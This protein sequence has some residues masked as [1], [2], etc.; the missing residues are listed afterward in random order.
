MELLSIY[1][2]FAIF[3][4]NMYSIRQVI[5][6][7]KIPVSLF[8][9]TVGAWFWLFPTLTLGVLGELKLIMLYPFFIILN[10]LSILFCSNY[11]RRKKHLP[12]IRNKVLA[13]TTDKVMVR[14][15]HILSVL[16][17]IVILPIAYVFIKHL[18]II[19]KAVTE[20]TS[21]ILPWDTLIYHYT[22]II[23]FAQE[24]TLWTF[25]N[26]F[27]SYF[28]G[29]E[30]IGLLTGLI[31]KK[32][33]P[34]IILNQYAI[35][36]LIISLVVVCNR[37]YIYS[38]E[39][40]LHFGKNI[41]TLFVIALFVICFQSKLNNIG[42][43]DIFQ[44]ATIL[45]CMAF[46]LEFFKNL[47][48][49]K[50]SSSKSI[51]LAASGASLALGLITKP[52][53]IA[54]YMYFNVLL[55]YGL[56]FTAKYNKLNIIKGLVIFNVIVL[57]LGSIFFIRNIVKYQGLS[58]SYWQASFKK[59]ILYNLN[60][61]HLFQLKPEI[62][63][64][65]LCVGV[66][67]A[68]IIYNVIKNSELWTKFNHYAPLSFCLC[69]LVVFIITPYTLHGQSVENCEWQIRLGM[70]FF[71]SSFWY[72]GF[73]F[74]IV[75][76]FC[77]NLFNYSLKI[78]DV[79]LLKYK[80]RQFLYGF[81]F[82]SGIVMF[83]I[84]PL[85]YHILPPTSLAQY[86]VLKAQNPSDTLRHSK[87]FDKFYHTQRPLRVYAINAPPAGLYG[88]NW[89]HQLFYDHDLLYESDGAC[90]MNCVLEQFK[91]HFVVLSADFTQNRAAKPLVRNILDQEK[92]VKLVY[93]DSIYRLYQV[94]GSSDSISMPCPCKS[95][96][97]Q[98]YKRLK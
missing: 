98:M 68:A 73:N 27:Q 4:W 1:S 78:L 36:F 51:I 80:I 75:L 2:A 83:I 58:D 21:L 77:K 3:G 90:R 91:P 92:R 37:I 20:P 31:S 6:H 15:I 14:N 52:T 97:V 76:S 84:T 39:K 24:K 45:S 64:F 12:L 46:L 5:V 17:L 53:S 61:P 65:L 87:I 63:L 81:L 49:E 69:A 96:T 16:G 70:A 8:L 71:I 7:K 19:N 29:F 94:I 56:I 55:A 67:L 62:I 9:C 79:T 33:W 47:S 66:L 50:I 43:N 25:K 88:Q 35:L 72:I 41:F 85:V 10:F 44:T 40:K 60:N 42:K 82:I 59:N 26:P 86:D 38:D 74:I 34:F 11:F 28:Y 22:G 89:Q 32:I 54:Y 95:Q 30:L 57:S 48:S 23:E 13:G 18:F 93:S